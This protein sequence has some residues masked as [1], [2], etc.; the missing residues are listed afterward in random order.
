MNERYGKPHADKYQEIINSWV[1]GEALRYV[2]SALVLRKSRHL[3]FVV[4][5]VR[6]K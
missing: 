4:R 1:M 2:T 3:I 6:T 5:S